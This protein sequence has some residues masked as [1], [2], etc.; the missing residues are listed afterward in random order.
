MWHFELFKIELMAIL[1]YEKYCWLYILFMLLFIYMSKMGCLRSWNWTTNFN[2]ICCQNFSLKPNSFLVFYL[3][4]LITLGGFT[5]YTCYTCFKLYKKCY[6][7]LCIPNTRKR[8][9]TR[10]Q[11]CYQT[12][13]NEIVFFFKI[14]S[15]KW[16]IFKKMLML[17]QLEQ[18]I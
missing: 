4:I 9:Q 12:P 6:K 10:F 3:F 13:K 2:C 16:T 1:N 17:K 8:S 15:K 14:L 5:Q 18:N 11:G 7:N